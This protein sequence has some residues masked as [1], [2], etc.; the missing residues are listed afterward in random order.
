M[1]IAW[2]E[3]EDNSASAAQAAERAL[4]FAG[5]WFAEPIFGSGNYPQVM[6]D[7]VIIQSRLLNI[8]SLFQS[9]EL[10][11]DW[12]EECGGW[13]VGVAFADVHRRRENGAERIVRFFR[14]EF[15]FI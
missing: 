8:N 12:T 14:F 13:V 7:Q 11:L 6:I 5:G 10:K 2:A 4:Q 15:L 9:N 1:N 3:P